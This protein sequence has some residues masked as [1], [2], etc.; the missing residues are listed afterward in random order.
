MKDAARV[1]LYRFPDPRVLWVP[2]YNSPRSHLPS[3][4]CYQHAWPAL[5]VLGMPSH[6]AP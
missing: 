1:S 3:C 2:G 5:Q 4:D 6:S